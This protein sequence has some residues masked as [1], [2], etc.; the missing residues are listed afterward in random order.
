MAVRNDYF[1]HFADDSRVGFGKEVIALFGY[2]GYGMLWN[3]VEYLWGCPDYS[4]SEMDFEIHTNTSVCSALFTFLC[5]QGVL[6][7]KKDKLYSRIKCEL[8][9]KRMERQLKRIA[10]GKAGAEARWGK[11]KKVEKKVRKP[12][13]ATPLNLD[14]PIVTKPKKKVKAEVPEWEEFMEYSL[15]QKPRVD[16][17][18]LK[19]KY[20]AWKVNNWKDGNDKPIKNWKS[21]ILH[22]LKFISEVQE[23]YVDPKY[24]RKVK[25]EF[26]YG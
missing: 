5:E 21:K 25:K 20:E 12:F 7:H 13:V 14:E 16:T 1:P 19:L 6:S 15:K 26:N 17:K 24:M 22:N 3:I 10:A 23:D 9:H 18:E 11:G 2:G 4:C 8:L